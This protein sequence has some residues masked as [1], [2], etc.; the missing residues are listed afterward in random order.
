[1]GNRNSQ[2]SSLPGINS[3]SWTYN[4]DDE[5]LSENYDLSGNVT[6]TGGKSYTYDSENH[7]TSANNGAIRLIYDGDGYRVAK[8]VN[9]VTTQYLVNDLNPTGLPQVVEE[10]VNGVVTRQYTYGLQR[11]SENQI[12]N[13]AWT[14]SFYG[15]DGGGNVRNLTDASGVVTDT[16]EYDAFGNALVMTGSTPNVYLYRGEQYDSDLGLYYLRARYYNS[17]T[18][19]FVSIDPEKG[20]LTDPATLRR[21]LYANGD[22]TNYVDPTGHEASINTALMLGMISLTATAVLPPVAKEVNC[23]LHTAADTLLKSIA[24]TG[25]TLVSLMPDWATCSAKAT[26]APAANEPNLWSWPFNGNDWPLPFTPQDEVCTTG[27]FAYEMNRRPAVLSCCKAHDDCYTQYQ[28]N[29]SSFF[30]LG[31]PG[32]CKLICNA[33]VLACLATADMSIGK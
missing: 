24:P 32:P 15:Y 25:Y 20:I 21:Y 7:M 8:I 29:F 13:G 28:C 5:L 4:A 19:R 17:Q 27:P 30:A 2:N 22:P 6:Y 10:V 18:G 33:E 31:L 9:G 26:Y 1:M 16:Y 3:G 12:I 14:V 23:V 11:I